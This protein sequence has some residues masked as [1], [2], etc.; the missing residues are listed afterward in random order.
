MTLGNDT[1]IRLAGLA[2]RLYAE[3][4][5]LL[6]AGGV[7]YS[8]EQVCRQASAELTLSV[9]VVPGGGGL[10]SE[11]RVSARVDDESADGPNTWLS[12]S[13]LRWSAVKYGSARLREPEV[14]ARLSGDTRT[15]LGQL[16]NDWKAANR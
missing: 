14:T 6:R 10:G 4:R 16:V 9:S 2:D 8:E 15:L 12:S 11:T 13:V 7:K 5:A 1:D 3:A